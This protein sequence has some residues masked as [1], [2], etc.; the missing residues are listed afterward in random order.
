MKAAIKKVMAF[1]FTGRHQVKQTPPEV[2]AAI[3]DTTGFALLI[4]NDRESQKWAPRWLAQAGLAV[5]VC[6]NADEGL[7]T[8]E[9]SKPRVVIVDATVKT[10]AGQLAMDAFRARLGDEAPLIALCADADE[11]AIAA[12][13]DATDIVRQPYDWNVITRRARRAIDMHEMMD[14]LR[15]ARANLKSVH[16]TVRSVERDRQRLETTDKITQLP[17]AIRFRQLL[18]RATAG[19]RGGTA[20]LALLVIGLDSFWLVNDAVGY[21]NANRLLASFA[22]RLRQTMTD[23]RVVGGADRRSITAMAARLDG[24]RFAMLIS[25]GD[26]EHIAQARE[27]LHEQLIEPFEIGGQTIY[28]TASIGAAVYPRDCSTADELLYHAESAMFDAQDAGTGFKLHESRSESKRRKSLELDSMLRE[29]VKNGD[30]RVAFQPITDTE[31]GSVVAAEALL[32]WEHPEEGYISPAEFVPFAERTGQMV[33]IG[34]FVI[35]SACSQLRIWLDAGAADIRVAVNLSLCQLLRGN[36][37]EIVRDALDTYQLDPSLLELELSERGVLNKR[38]EV[39]E[40]V[41]ELKALG[42]RISIDD[43]GTGQAA[44]A[45]LK[46]LPIDVIKIDRSYVSGLSTSGRNETIA[47]SMVALAHGLNATVITEGV[48]SEEQLDKIRDWGSQEYQG[49]LCSPAVS[50]EEFTARFA[51]CV[52]QD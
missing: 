50:G 26:A 43:F 15:S 44:I 4:T 33:E 40:Q 10:R 32:R 1:D 47:A 28:V 30:L 17:N 19:S 6:N 7:A 31:T 9:D 14:E 21:E 24:P 25:G 29:A 48:E 27:A 37:V 42:V 13:S 52:T 46:D 35:E 5:K 3:G 36:I 34:Q 18:S 38:V 49:F 2:P 45:Y 41:H 11:S 12:N 16:Q 51:T 8:A 39:I 22:E 20:E 23:P